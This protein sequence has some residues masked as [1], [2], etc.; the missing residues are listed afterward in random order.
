MEQ[1]ALGGRDDSRVAVAVTAVWPKVNQTP[2]ETRL[3]K[4]VAEAKAAHD[5]RSV[6]LLEEMIS[7]VREGRYGKTQV[8]FPLLLPIYRVRTGAPPMSREEDV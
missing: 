8:L 4:A 6:R 7:L 2:Y 1:S 5:E 3:T